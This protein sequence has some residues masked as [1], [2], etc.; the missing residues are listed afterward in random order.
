MKLV[1]AVI[2]PER[3]DAVQEELQKVLDED[4]NYRLTV[5]TVEDTARSTA[6]SRCSAASACGPAWCRRRA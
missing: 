3:L 5:D 1:V 2:R 4:D 6:K